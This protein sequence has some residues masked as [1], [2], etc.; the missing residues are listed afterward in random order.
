[1]I[2][3]RRFQASNEEADHDARARRLRSSP[4]SRSP[5]RSGGQCE[6][7]TDVDGVYHRRS[8]SLKRAEAG[9]DSYDEMLELAFVGQQGHAVA[10]VEFAAK[11]DVASES[12]PPLTTT[13]EPS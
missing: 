6:I 7:Y 12:A 10:L 9:G 4:P 3:V 11:Y 13:Q 2:I 1:V 8:P 5:R